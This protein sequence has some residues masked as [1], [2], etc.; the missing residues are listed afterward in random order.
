ML[1]QALVGSLLTG[2]LA[3]A[4]Q[5]V[6]KIRCYTGCRRDPDG[7]YCEPTC[8]FGFLDTSLADMTA[9]LSREALDRSR[10][11]SQEENPP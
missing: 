3:L 2:G 7:E 4:S 6:A 8:Q 5:I 10:E 9:P 11:S 1:D